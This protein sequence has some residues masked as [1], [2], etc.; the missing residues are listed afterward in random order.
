M[1]ISGLGCGW[2]AECAV[3]NKSFRSFSNK[4]VVCSESCRFLSY[5]G[6][7]VSGCWEWSGPLLG[8]YGTL[9]LN[10]NRANGRRK[11]VLAHRYSYESYHGE[12]P[13]GMCVMHTCD[14][15]VCTNPDHLILGTRGDNNKDRSAKGRSGSRTYSEDEKAR[16]SVM[17]RGEANVAA[18]LND[19]SAA[20]IKYSRGI[21]ITAF[22]A[23]YGVSK[24]TVGHIRSGRAWK[25][26]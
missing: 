13:D 1:N 25:H 12:I 11:Q 20:H 19:K 8:G 2:D 24:S 9:F 22:M 23:L 10:T 7:S 26:V 14:N 3:C 6:R 21:S 18:K 17:F 5:C 16:Y 4:Q 15:P